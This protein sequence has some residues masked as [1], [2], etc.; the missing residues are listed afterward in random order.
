MTETHAAW[1]RALDR[2]RTLGDRLAATP[3]AD[4]TELEAFEHLVDQTSLFFAWETLHA[5]PSRPFFHRHNDLVS[6][7]GGPNADNVYRHARIDPGRRYRIHGRMHSCDEFLLALRAGFMHNEIW[8]TKAQVTAS[9][10]GIGPGDEFE[11]FLGGD[12]LDPTWPDAVAIPDGVIMAS[13]REYYYAWTAEEPATILIECLDPDPAGELTETEFERRLEQSLAQIEDSIT[14]WDRYMADNRADRVDNEFAPTTVK[15]GKGLP[16]ARY[17]F[18]FWNLEPGQ[19]LIIEC[20]EPQARYWA[21][22]LYMMH[23]FELVDPYGGISSRNQ[24]QSRVDSDGKARY[25]LAATDPGVPNW[26]DTR[27][28]SAG[29]CTV[30]WFWP[31][32]DVE[33]ALT[34]RVVPLDD[35]RNHLPDETPEVSKTARAEELAARRAHLRWRF[36]A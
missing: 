10:L 22:Q 35:V 12:P 5:D 31:T 9:D 7:W 15:V 28:R 36:R 4:S 18:C 34:S 6:Q 20:D 17:E 1:G 32:A 11:L 23:T 33:P 13:V 21:T 16:M 3:P 26:L 24:A 8:G 14:Y 2:L 19:A 25:V 30:R 29:L 27:G